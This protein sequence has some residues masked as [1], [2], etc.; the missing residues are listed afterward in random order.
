MTPVKATPTRTYGGQTGDERLAQRRDDLATAAF[1]LV[2]EHGWRRLTIETLCRAA[3]L[4]KRYFYESFGSLDAVIAAVTTRLADEAI[5]V[6]LAAIRPDD[7]ADVVA[8]RAVGAFVAHLTDDP[9]RARVLFGAVPAGDA[10]AGHRAAAIRQ[11]ITTVATHGRELHDLP[12]G[13][14]ID[15]SAAMLVGGT[16][17]AVLDWLDGELDYPREAFV[18]DLVALW[19]VIGDAASARA[20]GR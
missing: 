2:A 18:D 12:A 8:R 16:S 7:P 10:A 17:Q 13:P 15:L 14:V 19:Q 1:A 20:R 6:T 5:A 4:N 9:R 3:G 11:V